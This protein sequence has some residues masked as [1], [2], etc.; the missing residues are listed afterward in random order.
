MQEAPI[1]YPFVPGRGLVLQT[2]EHHRLLLELPES[3]TLITPAS[4]TRCI[5]NDGE[6]SLDAATLSG[7][8]APVFKSGPVPTCGLN[9]CSSTHQR[10][11]ADLSKQG[12]LPNGG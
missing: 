6:H 3:H 11:M 9:R 12:L 8:A 2:A 7:D 1:T 5:V 10:R 4:P